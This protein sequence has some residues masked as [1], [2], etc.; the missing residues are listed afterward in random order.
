MIA[1]K[2]SQLKLDVVPSS[3]IA[4]N[5]TNASRNCRPARLVRRQT[6]HVPHTGSQYQCIISHLLGRGNPPVYLARSGPAGRT[7]KLAGRASEV[8]CY[9]GRGT[10]LARH[11]QTYDYAG[12]GGGTTWQRD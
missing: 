10:I 9:R 11:L 7:Y 5:F 4:L 1:G 2:W 6:R 3:T 12:D 8:Y